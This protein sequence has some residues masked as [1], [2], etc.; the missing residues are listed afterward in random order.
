[1]VLMQPP[2]ALEEEFTAWYDTEHVPERA[3]L[4]GFKTALRY[5]NLSGYPRFMAIYDLDEVATLDTPE[6]QAVSGPNFSPWT[7]RVTSRVQ[8]YR[9]AA[10]QVY[11]GDVVTQRSSRVLL[12]RLRAVGA[13]KDEAVVEAA[14][15][16]FEGRPETMGLRVFR[17]DEARD[18]D[19]F[20]LVEMTPPPQEPVDLKGFGDLIRH[21]DL[22]NL[23]TPY[24]PGG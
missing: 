5:V 10:E 23:Y 24:A 13:G 19:Y 18:T 3:A 2:A 16:A 9:V 15:K 21:V 6:Y 4:P 20:C 8:V 11:P 7:K 17:S 14:R 1:M 12:V 22:V